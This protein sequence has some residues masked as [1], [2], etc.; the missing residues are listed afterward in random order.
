MIFQKTLLM[1]GFFIFCF[2]TLG[3]FYK[4]AIMVILFTL[5]ISGAALGF[6][7]SFF[8]KSTII[9]RIIFFLTACIIYGL[10]LYVIDI[11]N[12]DYKLFPA[13]IL[14]ASTI[15]AVIV[16]NVTSAPSPVYKIVHRLYQ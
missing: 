3:M 8:K 12:S 4:E 2:E 10:A 7:I 11:K 1:A 9:Q 15:S 5:F 6:I 14:F 13:K 16:D